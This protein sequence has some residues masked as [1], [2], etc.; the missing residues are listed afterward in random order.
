MKAQ[1]EL[2]QR[3]LKLSSS[4]KTALGDRN[5]LPETLETFQVGF[6]PAFAGY[7]FDLM[8]GRIVVPIYDAYDNWLGFAGRKIDYYSTQVKEYYQLKT[9]NLQGLDRFMK[10][11]V[12]KWINSPYQ[13]ANHLFNLNRAKKHIYEV[14]YCIIVEGYFDVMRLHQLGFKNVV[15][16]SGT[17]LTETQCN[18]IYRYCNKVLIMLDGDDAGKNATNKTMERAR[19]NSIFAN[20]VELPNSLDPDDLDEETMKIIDTEII[21]S[22]EELYIKL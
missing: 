9:S 6:C 8:N 15:A 12:S 11:K 5:F 3:E 13:K 22:V 20:V 16:L 19:Q 18:L 4:A 1:I 17:S 7:D 21:N 10:W 2:F 14:G